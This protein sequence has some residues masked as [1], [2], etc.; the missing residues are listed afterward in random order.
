M[1]ESASGIPNYLPQFV[2]AL[3]K[4]GAPQETMDRFAQY[5]NAL[6]ADPTRMPCPFCFAAG[7]NGQLMAQ[8]ERSGTQYVRCKVC[9]KEIVVRQP[10]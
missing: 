5:W 9:R 2:E 6:P 10:R 1:A 7:Y 8:E 4:E 3:R